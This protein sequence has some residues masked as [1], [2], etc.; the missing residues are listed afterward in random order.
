M[1]PAEEERAL[2]DGV[3]EP[4]VDVD[5]AA[6]AGLLDRREVGLE[7]HVA[8]G[9][10]RVRVGLGGGHRALVDEDRAD[11]RPPETAGFR[12]ARDQ[13]FAAIRACTSSAEPA[14]AISV[15][16]TAAPRRP[17]STRYDLW[18]F[19]RTRSSGFRRRVVAVAARAAQARNSSR[20]WK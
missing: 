4:A 13:P 2:A 5:E 15:G 8:L 7:H 12:T 17:S 20:R 16:I 3:G 14:A 11:R 9:Q 6:L 10:Q 18:L 19:Q 1:A